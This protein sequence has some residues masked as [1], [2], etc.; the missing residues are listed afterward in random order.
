[1]NKRTYQKAELVSYVMALIVVGSVYG[2]Y[3]N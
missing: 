3:K 2:Y 1:M